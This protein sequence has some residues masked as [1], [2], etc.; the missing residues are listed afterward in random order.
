MPLQA[1]DVLFYLSG[2]EL[3]RKLLYD[4]IDLITDALG[5]DNVI[6]TS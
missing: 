4:R 3:G 1:E 5:P 6:V 2:R